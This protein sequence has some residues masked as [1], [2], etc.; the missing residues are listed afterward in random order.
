MVSPLRGGFAYEMKVY[1]R[2]AEAKGFGIDAESGLIHSVQSTAA[3]VHDLSPAAELLDGEET[4]V[5]RIL[6]ARVLQS[7]G[8]G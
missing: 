5:S 6:A 8:D 7:P 4:L 2:C 3:N 1:Q